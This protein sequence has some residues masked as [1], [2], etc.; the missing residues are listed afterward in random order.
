MEKFNQIFDRF[1]VDY[2]KQNPLALRISEL[3]KVEGETV[4]HDHIALRTFNNPKVNLAKV[5]EIFIKVGYELNGS[6]VFE[7]KRLLGKHL[8]KLSE[9]SEYA[10]WLYV[11]GYRANHFA[12]FINALSK[13]N[14]IRKVNEFV[15]TNGY[16][17]NI[18]NDLE[19]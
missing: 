9:E 4:V 19:T 15:K 14:N 12:I 16:L 1:W 8:E 10:A 5:A 3:F 2:T 7:E 17:M 18:V 6:Y 11:H 13:Y